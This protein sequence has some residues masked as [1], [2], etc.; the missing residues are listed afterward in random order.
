MAEGRARPAARRPSAM[1]AGRPRDSKETPGGARK[2]ALL[3]DGDG[4]GSSAQPP[5]RS[6]LVVAAAV[7]EEAGRAP[8]LCTQ[9]PDNETAPTPGTGGRR[10][11]APKPRRACRATAMGGWRSGL[12]KTVVGWRWCETGVCNATDGMSGG[13]LVKRL[14][15]GNAVTVTDVDKRATAAARAVVAARRRMQRGGGGGGGRREVRNVADSQRGCRFVSFQNAFHTHTMA[16]HHTHHPASLALA[17][18]GTPLVALPTVQSGWRIRTSESGA[19]PPPATVTSRPPRAQVVSDV[20]PPAPA[21][22][23]AVTNGHVKQVRKGRDVC[24]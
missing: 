14:G 18:A 3:G 21:A 4:G 23:R 22:A 24:V 20:A 8:C 16:T 2:S 6:S 10:L 17:K 19:C 15:V 9:G 5:P 1:A 13:M 11:R 12:V 7:A